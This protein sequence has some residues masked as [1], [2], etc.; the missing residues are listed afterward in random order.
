MRAGATEPSSV[1]PLLRA[2]GWLGLAACIAAMTVCKMSNND[3]WIHLKTG[4]YVLAHWVPHKDP[5]SFTAADHD[6]VAHEWL[7]AV[8]FHLVHAG[9]GVPGL[10]FAKALIVAATCA[11]L[12]ATARRAG[13]RLAVILPAFALVLYIGGARFQERPHIFSYLMTAVYLWLFYRYREGGR[14]RRW[15]YGLPPAQAIWVNLHGGHVIGLALVT[16]FAVG[17]GL[18]WARTRLLDLGRGGAAPT[19]DVGLLAALV[20][21]CVLASLVTPYGP[22]LLAMPF[23]ITGSTLQMQEIF[24]W[25]PPYDDVYN[26]STMFVFYMLHLGVLSASFFLVQRDRGGGAGLAGANRALLVTLA[27]VYAVLGFLWIEG[28]G[29]GWT[30]ERLAR[31]L[32]VL[33]GLFCAFT[34][35][36]LRAVDLTQAGLV[37]FFVLLSLQHC[38][39]V[40]DAALGTFVPLTASV[41]TLFGRRGW[42]ETPVAVAA[43]AT[44]L[45]AVAAHASIFTYYY[46]FAG[47]GREK[48]IGVADAMPECAVDF[49]VRQRLAGHAFV[50]Y[51]GAGML[52][53]RTTPAVKVN[54]DSRA[55]VY[56]EA[57]FRE[58][59][60]AFRTPG[61]MQAYLRRHPIDFFLLEYR[62]IYPSTI[63]TLESSG[64]WSPVYYD[65]DW[66]ILVA[67]TPGNQPLIEREAFRVLRPY[68]LGAPKV[69]AS[70]AARLLD[71]AERVIRNCPRS[72]LGQF[73]K[74][75]ALRALGRYGE[76]LEATRRVIARQPRNAAAYVD[77]AEAYA[78]MGERAAAIGALQE[79]LRLDPKQRLARDRLESLGNR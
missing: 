36:N 76:A 9:F 48:G 4:E 38:R 27:A 67:R 51:A 54:M 25:K 22:R 32:Y 70:N 1:P 42:R 37:T 6:Y 77:L 59:L 14:D 19:P 34:A 29:V 7:A 56:G 75:D 33:V 78:G 2:V 23:K 21:A 50:S 20:P 73:V 46:D 40:T 10:I 15:L 8:F 45:L 43:G 3:I 31:I 52:I 49:I 63:T 60:S 26:R 69:D 66:A 64:A 11:L 13:G 41:S 5:Y 39:A 30:A 16:L 28:P 74:G 47:S 53:Q 58:Y 18:G 35:L 65:D 62:P 79:A 24:E 55:D 17:E 57:L 44:L 12:A 71:E 61:G 68:E 72:L